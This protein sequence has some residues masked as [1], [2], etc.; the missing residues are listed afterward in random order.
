MSGPTDEAGS[1]SRRSLIVHVGLD[2]SDRALAVSLGWTAG[3]PGAEVRL[4]RNGTASWEA[5]TSDASGTVVYEDLLPGRYRVYAGRRLS[6][7]E[8]RAVGGPRRA[9]GDGR[10][11][12]FSETSEVS[13][14]LYA[15][16]PGRL[17]ISEVHGKPPPSW[18][19]PGGGSYFDGLYFEVYNNSGS[20]EYLDGLL[21]GLAYPGYQDFDHTPCSVSEPVRTDPTGIHGRW[22][23]QF[24]GSGTDHPIAPGEAKVVAYAAI[25]HT[26]VHPDLLDLSDADFEVG[27]WR[28]ANNPA[29]PDMLDVGLAAWFP[30]TLVITG[31][32]FYL[33]EPMNPRELPIVWRDPQGRGYVHVPAA[34]VIDAVAFFALSPDQDREHP[35]CIPLASPVFERYEGGLHEIGL[36]VTTPDEPLQRFVLR[37]EGGRAIL[38]NTNTSA[39]DFGRLPHTPG[40]VP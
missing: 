9:F 24:P 19:I 4:N 7:E 13:L 27:G 2:G 30:S 1:D 31:D 3:V 14:E 40:W 12:D 22:F 17:V 25:D 15:D 18:E 28:S 16:R 5:R 10:T 34:S 37:T 36:G 11:F 8:A 35:P 23:L 33:A 20:T 26:S 32:L 38:Q 6:A 39:V 29:V 21:F